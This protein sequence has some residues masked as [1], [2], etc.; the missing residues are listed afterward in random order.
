MRKFI[1]TV[2]IIIG[3]A[4]ILYPLGRNMYADYQQRQLLK[5]WDRVSQ[6]LME[7]ESEDKHN[8]RLDEEEDDLERI[9]RLEAE[10]KERQAYIAQNLEG[11]LIIDKINLRLPILTGT[12]ARNLLISAASLENTAKAGEVG[13]YV[14]TG[15]RNYGYGM[16]FNRLDELDVG[17]LMTVEAR[18]SLFIYEVRE[19]LY[20]EPED[21]WVLQG[22]QED[23]EITLI[24]CHPERNPTQ[25]LIIKGILSHSLEK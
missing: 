15:H 16:H 5:E 8:D 4:I 9:R 24:T 20:V 25:R 7:E 3:L 19:K 1:S 18:N 10:E 23:A 13:N 11:L 14:I 21:V 22:K 6:V 2:L 12:S 17:D